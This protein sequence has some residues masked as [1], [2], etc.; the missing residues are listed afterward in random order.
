MVRTGADKP[1]ILVI[2]GHDIG[3]T[4]VSAYSIGLMGYRTPL[5]R[6]R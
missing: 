4:N 1:N 3:Q 2:F 5:E 6:Y